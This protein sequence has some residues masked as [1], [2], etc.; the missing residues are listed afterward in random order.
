MQAWNKLSPES[1]CKWI[2]SKFMAND[3]IENSNSLVGWKIIHLPFLFL[4]W[5]QANDPSSLYFFPLLYFGFGSANELCVKM[6]SNS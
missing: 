3:W 5:E 1:S 2:L 4:L 6:Y